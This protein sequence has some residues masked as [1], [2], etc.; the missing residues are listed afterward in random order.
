MAASAS[1]A[2]RLTVFKVLEQ[3]VRISQF[4]ASWCTRARNATCSTPLQSPTPNFLA[5]RLISSSRGRHCRMVPAARRRLHVIPTQTGGHFSPKEV[6]LGCRKSCQKSGGKTLGSSIVRL[7]K[8]S[9]PVPNFSRPNPVLMIDC[10]CEKRRPSLPA[11][12]AFREFITSK[13][14]W[15]SNPPSGLHLGPLPS[16]GSE[17]LA[18]TAAV[19][20]SKTEVWSSSGNLSLTRSHV[21]WLPGARGSAR[22][23]RGATVTPPR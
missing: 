10:K 1:T 6:S 18:A 22:R 19:A 21:A 20:A 16:S 15:G 12:D 9:M 17:S 11:P 14:T 2:V 13:M 3:S 8:A 23:L 5:S 7:Q 4:F